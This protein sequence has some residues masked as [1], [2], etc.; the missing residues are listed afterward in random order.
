MVAS[1]THNY[2]PGVHGNKN[3]LIHCTSYDVVTLIVNTLQFLHFTPQSLNL[4]NNLAI[5][6]PLMLLRSGMNSLMMWE[7]KAYLFAKAYLP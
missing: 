6:M 7:L 4:S 3:V 2:T 1:Q 5:V